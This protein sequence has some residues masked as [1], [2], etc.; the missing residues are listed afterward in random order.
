MLTYPCRN[1]NT[2]RPIVAGTRYLVVLLLMNSPSVCFSREWRAQIPDTMNR[3][4]MN[5]GY[6]MYWKM[7]QYCTSASV[8]LP[9]TPGIPSPL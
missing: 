4:P 7:S 5:Q 1:P 8:I 3:I 9:T 6:T 2:N